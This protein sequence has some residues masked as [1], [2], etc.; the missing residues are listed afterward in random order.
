MAT[1]EQTVSAV[2]NAIGKRYLVE[3]TEGT[4]KNGS[5]W[6]D[7]YSDGWVE[8]GG[9]IGDPDVQIPTKIEIVFPV[10]FSDIPNL[11]FGGIGKEDT[12]T[13]ENGFDKD[14]LTETGFVY[15]GL[16]IVHS[17]YNGFH[18]EAKGFAA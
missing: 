12:S 7:R 18:W 1:A 3:H 11:S 9:K 5:W 10:P 4:I 14:S 17:P 2:L 16:Q 6:A 15:I 8:Q 13:Y